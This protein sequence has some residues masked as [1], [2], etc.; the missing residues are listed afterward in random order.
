MSLYVIANIIIFVSALAGFIFGIIRFS[1]HKALY[2][3]MINYGVGCIALGR[4]Y[5]IIR[6]VT[7]GQ[8]TGEFQLGFLGLAGSLLFF[9]SANFGTM[10]SLA[11]DRSARF[12]KSRMIASLAPIAMVAI[13]VIFVL[14]EDFPALA[15]ILGAVLLAFAMQSAYF[16]LKHLVL[17]DVDFGIVNCL[18]AYNLAALIYAFLCMA[19]FIILCHE[20]EVAELIISLAIGCVAG[21]IVPLVARG[22]KK[23]TM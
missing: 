21:G 5:Q 9:F 1:R 12:R 13:Y 6:L 8:I 19:E 18:K 20:N 17:P 11:D 3:R 4:L 16:N 2:P 10:D 7:G 22:V 23:W 15:K 14:C